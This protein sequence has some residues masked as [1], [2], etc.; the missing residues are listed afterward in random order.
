MIEIRMKLTKTT[1]PLVC[2][3]LI[4]IVIAWTNVASAGVKYAPGK[5]EIDTVHTRVSFTVPHF[6]ITLVEGRFNNVKGD[7]TLGAPFSTSKA[8]VTVQIESIDTGVTMRDDDLRSNNF[9]AAATY[10]TMT[11]VAKSFKGTPDACKVVGD[12]TIKDVTKEVTLDGK[13]KGMVT[14]PWGNQRAAIQLTGVINRKDFHLNYNKRME[15]GPEI[16]DE[17]TIRIF[18]DGIIQKKGK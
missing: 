11:F 3:A 17:V 16:G 8:N 15:I 7:F 18:A 14:D 10:P 9:F 2:A 1:F 5:Y 12:L 4:T 6:V 13:Y